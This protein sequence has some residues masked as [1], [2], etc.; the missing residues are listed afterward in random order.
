MNCF[1][2]TVHHLCDSPLILHQHSMEL[3]LNDE[4]SFHLE[5]LKYFTK[6]S[7]FQLRLLEFLQ[8]LFFLVHLQEVVQLLLNQKLFLGNLTF[9]YQFE[10]VLQNVLNLK[11][12]VILFQKQN[13]LGVQKYLHYQLHED[14]YELYF[15]YRA[16]SLLILPFF[17]LCLCCAIFLYL[18]FYCFFLLISPF[19]YD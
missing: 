3:D 6:L 9:W 10:R 1:L 13:L 12:Q 4:L 5:L 19:F 8:S 17:R 18:I 7:L 11:D 14:E 15:F 2:C 16:I